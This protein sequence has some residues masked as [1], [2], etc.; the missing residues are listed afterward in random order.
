LLIAV[1]WYDWCVISP[2]S[3]PTAILTVSQSLRVS[4]AWNAFRLLNCDRPRVRIPARPVLGRFFGI[5]GRDFVSR[6]RC[7]G[8]EGNPKG[9]SFLTREKAAFAAASRGMPKRTGSL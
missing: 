5:R 8:S 4:I 7:R 9:G 6:M 2:P 1:Q 3:P